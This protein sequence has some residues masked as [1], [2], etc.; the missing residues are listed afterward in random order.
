V[1]NNP[2][3][4]FSPGGHH[5]ARWVDLEATLRHGVDLQQPEAV[6]FLNRWSTMTLEEKTF[7]A[8]EI[9]V[10]R[11]VGSDLVKYTAFVTVEEASQVI[12]KF[13]TEVAAVVDPFTNS[14]GAVD[15]I[16]N[17]AAGALTVLTLL[18]ANVQR[19]RHLWSRI[20]RYTAKL[21][22]LRR[23]RMSLLRGL[24]DYL[25]NAARDHRRAPLYRQIGTVPSGL[26]IPT[27]TINK[28]TK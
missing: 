24:I 1:T 10:P 19:N 21:D 23:S 11:F 22:Q 13:R 28:D 5:L 17:G 18:A 15:F 9:L 20:H 26:L 27:T 6:T 12:S 4:Y 7:K 8:I 3:R 25:N 2:I 14:A 16:A